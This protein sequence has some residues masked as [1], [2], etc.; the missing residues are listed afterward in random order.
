MSST[1]P[2]PIGPA[3]TA[4]RGTM[5][6]AD[7]TKLDAYPAT[8]ASG[9]VSSVIEG[10]GLTLTAGTLALS[11]APVTVA[12][13]PAG[14]LS[15]VGQAL[16]FA[17]VSASQTVAGVVDLAAQTFAG[18]KTFVAEAVFSAGLVATGV[19]AIGAS[20]LLRSDLGAGS[21]DKCVTVGSSV[22]DGSVHA[23]AKVWVAATGIGGTQVDKAWIE[24]AGT[25]KNAN[26]RFVGSSANN[27]YLGCDDS[28]GVTAAFGTNTLAVTSAQLTFTDTA[29]GGVIFKMLAAGAVSW[30]GVDRSATIGADTQN[31]PT[32]LNTIA[33]GATSCRITNNLIPDPAATKVRFNI[34]PHGNLGNW[35]VV[36]GNG[37]FD[38]TLAAGAAA[39]TSF[40]WEVN[41]FN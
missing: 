13:S 3:T 16:T 37:Y 9:A 8:P 25:I 28:S 40:G 1:F 12:A 19:R 26:G 39:N 22:A 2:S 31:R 10:N 27:G 33:L 29:V 30:R 32:G 17:L 23:S 36:Q 38:L 11:Q 18:V 14:W 4:K 34:T 5:S 7:K 35:W 20:L 15:L 21:T 24:K 6:A 41:G